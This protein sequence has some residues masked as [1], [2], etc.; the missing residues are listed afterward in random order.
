VTAP[1]APS[2]AGPVV[3]PALRAAPQPTT[4]R[5]AFAALLDSLPGAAT[6]A[7][8]S[9]SEEGSR[10]SSDARPGQPP[11]GR[12]DGHPMLD[13]SAFLSG[14]PFALSSALA[15]DQPNAAPVD[16]QAS[17][18]GASLAISGTSA[19]TSVEAAKPAVARL[20]GERAFHLALATSGL[21]GAGSSPAASSA[22][23]D[24]SSF[25]PAPRASDSG[26]GAAEPSPTTRLP[27]QARGQTHAA[28]PPSQGLS[29]SPAS[30]LPS[31]G[32][33]PAATKAPAPLASRGADPLINP[34][35]SAVRAA[36]HDPARVGRKAEAA[37]APSVPRVATA[38]AASARGEPGDKSTDGSPHDPAA[39]AG[40]PAAQ[41]SAFGAPQAASVATG[42]S[43]GPF[44]A[45]AARDVAPLA[46]APAAP[47]SPAGA[48][49]KEIDVDLSPTGLEDVSMTMRLAGDKL[50]VVIRA[51]SSQT[52]GSIE[53]ARDAIAD[54]L[55][56]IGQP[57]DSL[58]IRQTGANAD[59]NANGYGA[60]ADDGSGSG[61]NQAGRGASG[62]GGSSD[63][64][65]S[66]RGAARDRGF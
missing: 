59:A 40:Q 48:P 28:A 53:G 9:A 61:E 34:T 5:F 11:S 2:A 47:H 50:S 54:R 26:N 6:K 65:S 16:P 42:P 66:R 57:L 46:K 44:D 62:Q 55:A 52:A 35:G 64:G 10:T 24:T 27:M 23:T 56:A 49:V 30:A 32:A 3:L 25:P 41:A 37:A 63:A 14:L 4:D 58:I 12:P 1:A 29:L 51:A 36:A 7:D 45:T 18:K 17:M 60:S 22:L 38:A 15:T 20:T 33:A 19:E 13:D 8:P 39:S 31:R 43:F 21:I